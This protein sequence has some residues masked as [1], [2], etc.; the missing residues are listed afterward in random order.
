MYIHSLFPVQSTGIIGLGI[1]RSVSAVLRLHTVRFSQEDLSQI[2][3]TI[4]HKPE[5][6]NTLPMLTFTSRLKIMNSA[7]TECAHVLDKIK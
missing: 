1:R 7:M 6:V 5:V 4:T 3:V 2:G